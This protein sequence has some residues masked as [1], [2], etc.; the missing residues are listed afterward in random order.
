MVV[1]DTNTIHYH[2]AMMIIL[3][4]ASITI[5]TMMH[6]WQLIHI[7]CLTKSKFPII[8]HFVVNNLTWVEIIIKYKRIKGIFK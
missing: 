4:A 8:F 7:A 1:V 2:P 3:E 6:P 5:G